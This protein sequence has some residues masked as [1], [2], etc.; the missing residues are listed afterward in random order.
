MMPDTSPTPAR[1][2]I[3]ILK[4]WFFFKKKKTYKNR[5]FFGL[6]QNVLYLALCKLSFALSAQQT[7]TDTFANS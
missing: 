1:P 2:D 4:D 5:H 3:T 7:K 6:K